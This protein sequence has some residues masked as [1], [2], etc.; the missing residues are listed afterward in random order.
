MYNVA[1]HFTSN[2]ISRTIET[3]IQRYL[4][5]KTA[6]KILFIW[7]P[8]RSGKTTLLRELSQEYNAPIF[9]FNLLSDQ[10]LFVPKRETL[11]TLVSTHKILLI[12]EIQYHPES[13]LALKVLYDE[14]NVKIIATGSSELRQ[15]TK[16]FD[17]LSARY[18]ELFCLPLSLEEAV[19]ASITL[20]YRKGE[21]NA[22][23]IKHFQNY[24]AYPEIFTLD[25]NEKEAKIDL[26]EKIIDT[27]VIK[28]IVSLYNLK[29]ARLAK[30][31]LLK[32]ALQIGN[33]VSAREIASSLQANVV[34]VTNYI[35]IFVKNHVLVPL[36]S[37][38]TNVRKAVS[39]NRKIFFLDIGVR[40]ALVKDFREIDLRPDKGGV[41]ENLVISEFT[42]VIKNHN[43]KLNLY[44]YREYR[45][46][47][48]DL[49]VENYTK[50]YFVYEI[51]SK[52][53]P[54]KPVFPLPHKLTVI[55][56]HNLPEILD[57]LKTIKSV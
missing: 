49:V 35:E 25:Q 26:L 32:V 44:F 19:D 18:Q 57:E 27:Y 46:K 14:F 22:A 33:E 34:T 2:M 31:I 30:D 29:N 42:K 37:F 8:R 17:S 36:P 4:K 52:S 1:V 15:K 41:F 43:L 51:K 54:V 45:G 50:H 47:E 38:R 12:D 6:H 10:E 28:D 21:V 40:N 9:N 39:E 11:Q 20:P 7:G 48:V 56:P 16:E 55:T 3:H 24:G 23:S 13:T 5:D 53:V